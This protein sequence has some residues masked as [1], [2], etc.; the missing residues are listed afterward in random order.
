MKYTKEFYRTML[1][2]TE[3]KLEEVMSEWRKAGDAYRARVTQLEIEKSEII[4]RTNGLCA[5]TYHYDNDYNYWS[6]SC[7]LEWQLSDGTPIENGMVYCTR[8]GKK[9]VEEKLNDEMEI[10]HGTEK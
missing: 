5:W 6:S 2:S 1:K 7:G 3:K 9:L 4:T 8:C 10:N